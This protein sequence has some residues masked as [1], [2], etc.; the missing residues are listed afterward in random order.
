MPPVRQRF[1]AR[2]RGV[3]SAA[4][5]LPNKQ[6]MSNSTDPQGGA[7][8]VS[9]QEMQF[10]RG[11]MRRQLM[12]WT[13][14]LLGI[15]ALG[16]WST[17][18]GDS[19]DLEARTAA[20]L[21]QVRS[22]HQKLTAEI[23]TLRKEIAAAPAKSGG[24]DELERRVEDAKAN[25]RMIESR[26]SAALDR[27]IAALEAG[28]ARGSAAAIASTQA[29][30]PADASAWDV[31]AILDRLYAVEMREGS[32]AAGASD[33]RISALERRIVQLEAAAQGVPLPAASTPSY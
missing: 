16:L 28:V 15:G 32:G 29:S 8:E 19:S 1:T 31:S 11:V 33:G 24:S 20:A 4:T 3:F 18:G 23:A 14:L 12:P 21:S 10:L 26:I 27:R 17:S 9:P 22:E 2:G 25:V 6:V 7:V 30:P 13:L 5:D